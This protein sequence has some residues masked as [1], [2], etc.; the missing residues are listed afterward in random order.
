MNLQQVI[1]EFIQRGNSVKVTAMD[2]QTLV[3]VSIV[4]PANASQAALKATALNKLK[5]VLGK[6]QPG[7]T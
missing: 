4:G 3:E 6:R 2:P 5:Y 7:R 1:F